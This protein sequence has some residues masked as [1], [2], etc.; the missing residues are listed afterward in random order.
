MNITTASSTPASQRVEYAFPATTAQEAF[1]FLDRLAP[2][3]PAYNISIRFRLSGPLRPPALEL[4]LTALLERH[5]S[6]RTVFAAPDGDLL[7]HVMRPEPVHLAID[8]VVG[9]D[10][11]RREEIM[12][13]EARGAFD[14]ETGPLF[15][16]RLLRCS[17]DQHFLLLTMHH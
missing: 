5:E 16:A 17:A 10:A 15:R 12:T 14:L 1:W 7:Q 3:D 13:V 4:A 8:D 6:L 9:W 11:D 2:G